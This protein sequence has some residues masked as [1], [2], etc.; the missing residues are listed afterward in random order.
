MGNI[1]MTGDRPT[2]RLHVGHLVGSLT[3]RVEIQKAG[4][5]DAMFIEIA[6]SQATT[7][8]SGNMQREQ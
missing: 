3:Q 7:D 8:N 4:D 1:I 2:G 5:Y 6:D